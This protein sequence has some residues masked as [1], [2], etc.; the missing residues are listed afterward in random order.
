MSETSANGAVKTPKNKTLSTIAFVALIAGILGF[1]T[2]LS[3]QDPPPAMPQHL[4]QHQ[5]KFDLK[6][7]LI[8]VAS[9]QNLPTEAE[10]AAGTATTGTTY[11]LKAVEKRINQGCQACHGAPNM[12][13]ST[14]ACKTGAGP[15]IP[16]HHPPKVECIKCH[17]K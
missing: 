13:L 2:F 17:R 9:E 5:L 1:F 14:H 10:L 7:Q 4:P 16:A 3:K 6:G 8:G 15:C 12:D 11:D